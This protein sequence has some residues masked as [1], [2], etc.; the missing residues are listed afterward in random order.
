MVAAPSR[1]LRRLAVATL[2]AATAAAYAPSLPGGYTFD[3]PGAVAERAD[4]GD[5]AAVAGRV[6]AALLGR[7]RAVTDLTFAAGRALHG[8]AAPPTR[9]VNLALHL[10][11]ALVV[12]GLLDEVLRR[13][14]LDRPWLALAA[15]ALW[16][17]HPLGSGAVAAVAQRAES[18]SALLAAAAVLVALRAPRWRRPALGSALAAGLV[19]LSLG[20]KGVGVVAF[21]GLALVLLAF[22]PG[23]RPD[24]WQVARRAAPLLLPALAF[25]VGLLLEVRGQ[26]DVGFSM[27]TLTPGDAWRSQGRALAAY[28][29]LAAWPAGQSPDPAMAPSGSLDAAALLGW[30]VVAGLLVAGGLA[31]GRRR[32]PAVRVA[33][34][35]AL[36]FLLW[37][38]PTSA[39]PIA[40]V[41]AEHRAYLAL[42]GLAVAAAAL[43]DHAL[44]ALLPSPR[45]AAAAGVALALGTSAVLGAALARRAALWGD[46]VALWREATAAAPAAFRP[47]VNLARALQAAGR[48]DEALAAWREALARWPEAR[49]QGALREVARLRALAEAGRP[50]EAA[51]GLE[52][53][54][55][56]VLPHPALYA[57]MGRLWIDLGEPRAAELLLSQ[58]AAIAAWSPEVFSA[59]G[60]AYAAQGRRDDAIRVTEAALRRTGALAD[61]V[62][63][64]RL[65]AEVGRAAEGCALLLEAGD[66]ALAEAAAL[67]CR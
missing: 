57:A 61:R 60:L 42:A 40:D 9:A 44:R 43:A 23:P 15:A 3:D 49:Q 17:L 26:H 21:A 37:L 47:Q 20:A 30:A 38:A 32:A 59:L 62:Q 18:L 28:L 5:P 4:L 55:G 53:L 11:A 8:P 35:G 33:G 65:L 22:S 41:M 56:R 14:G 54:P 64:A 12:L 29:R 46:P 66:A 31:L 27:T 34:F 36:W 45:A 13:A 24:R 39:L 25:G 67:G 63:L 51:A 7:G 52:V 10:L 2:L 50:G 1:R 58:A 19:L 6:P 16:A 48:G